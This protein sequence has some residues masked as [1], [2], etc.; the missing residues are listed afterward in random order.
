MV[1]AILYGALDITRGYD[2]ENNEPAPLDAVAAFAAGDETADPLTQTGEKILLDFGV[3][4]RTSPWNHHII[5]S[6]S[7]VLCDSGRTAGLPDVSTDY[8]EAALMAR[9]E[10]LRGYYTA[11]SARIHRT[12]GEAETEEQIE[13]RLT[14]TATLRER[15]DQYR[16]H[17]DAVS[18]V[19]IIECF[20]AK[21]LLEIQEAH[22]HYRNHPQH[23]YNS[24]S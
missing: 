3:G 10:T 21:S 1:R 12:T 24:Q 17:R 19:F 15:R 6:L 7:A 16:I 2:V 18:N 14:T 23:S 5:V 13:E 22:R 20:P 4:W 8:L 9:F 11:T